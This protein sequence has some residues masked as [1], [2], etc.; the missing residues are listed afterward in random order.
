MSPLGVMPHRTMRPYGLS[1]KCREGEGKLSWDAD[2]G[3][4]D[5]LAFLFPYQRATHGSNEDFLVT[6][7]VV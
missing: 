7:D 4:A 3:V 1:S 2:T 6:V 5:V